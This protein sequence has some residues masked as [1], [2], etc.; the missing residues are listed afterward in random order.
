MVTVIESLDSPQPNKRFWFLNMPDEVIVEIPWL[1]EVAEKLLE[2][3]P[4][5]DSLDSDVNI[6][7]EIPVQLPLELVKRIPPK[8]LLNELGRRLDMP[9]SMIFD[10]DMVEFIQG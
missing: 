4:T 10:R 5:Q 1:H 7:V 9:T 3:F 8:V 6:K 2:Q